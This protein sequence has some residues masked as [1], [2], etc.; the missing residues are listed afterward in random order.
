MESHDGKEKTKNDKWLGAAIEGA[1]QSGNPSIPAIHAPQ[2]LDLFLEKE[3]GN[4]YNEA[5]IASL[6]AQAQE[7]FKNF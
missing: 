4:T 1:K 3:S 2:R 5:W 7:I 6:Q